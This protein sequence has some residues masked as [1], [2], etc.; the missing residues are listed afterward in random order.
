[1]ADNSI[2]LVGNVT[3][4]PELRFTPG[5]QPVAKF[6]LAVNRRYQQNG[7]WKEQTSYFDIV[8]WG[9]LGENVAVSLSKGSRALVTGRIEQRAYETREGEKRSAVEIVADEIGPS[10]RWAQAAIE[11]NERRTGDGGSGGGYSGGGGGYSGGGNS[12][13]GNQ[14]PQGGGAPSGG[15]QAPS[16]DDEEPF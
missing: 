5:G 10:L 14:R 11:R 4:D 8:A 3:R 9:S 12:G 7:E 6:G 13:G 15:G 2:T 1:M 16:Y